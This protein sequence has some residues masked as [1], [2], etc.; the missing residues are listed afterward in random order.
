MQHCSR[1][2]IFCAQPASFW[3]GSE[4]GRVVAARHMRGTCQPMLRPLRGLVTSTPRGI[5]ALHGL[6]N[7]HDPK[8]QIIA[9]EAC[10]VARNPASRRQK[11]RSG[12]H[13]TSGWERGAAPGRQAP[14]PASNTARPQMNLVLH[15]RHLFLSVSAETILK[16]PVPLQ[17][18]R[19]TTLQLAAPHG[20]GSPV[21][22][23]PGL[24]SGTRFVLCLSIA[25]YIELMYLLA[26]HNSSAS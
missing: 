2:L 25:Q 8:P 23:A 6:T 12:W 17:H 9:S 3:D 7:R 20:S 16:N 1:Y 14:R 4:R 11:R 15:T 24:R 19:K 10:R 26:W 18:A 13:L 21:H 5:G 22:L